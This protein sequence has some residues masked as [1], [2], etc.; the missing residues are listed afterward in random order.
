[1]EATGA[2]ALVVGVCEFR[3]PVSP[4]HGNYEREE[5]RRGALQYDDDAVAVDC[6]AT[7]LNFAGDGHTNAHDGGDDDLAGHRVSPGCRSTQ[8][9]ALPSSLNISGSGTS[10]KSGSNGAANAFTVS[11]NS[12]FASQPA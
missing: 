10:R 5:G 3:E 9:I 7:H 4:D 6:G 11:Q 8:M 2:V 1:V 12:P